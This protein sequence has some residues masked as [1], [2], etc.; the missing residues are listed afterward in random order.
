MRRSSF[1][2]RE[3]SEIN[4]TPLTD[5]VFVLLLVFMV[6]TPALVSRSLPVAVPDVA[7]PD[8][9]PPEAITV[10]LDA[11]RRVYV[12]DAE[13]PMDSLVFR[14]GP[15]IAS[16][17]GADTSDTATDSLAV[18]A[19]VPVVVRADTAARY[20]DVVR[21]LSAVRA[22]GGRAVLGVEAEEQQ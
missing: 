17:S 5:V 14:L 2:D 3:L 6:A 16:A 21:V 15:L 13:V 12:E 19:S 4:I 9:A 1:E 18:R 10:S 11:M 22:S 7:S 8:E 20:G